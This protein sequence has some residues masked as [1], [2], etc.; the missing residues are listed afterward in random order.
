MSPKIGQRWIRE[1]GSSKI[2][3]EVLSG[4]PNL[5]GVI[6]QVIQNGNDCFS[7]GSKDSW[8]FIDIG[9]VKYTYLNGQDRSSE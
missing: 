8:G 5:L 7:L 9:S 1:H 6:V 4:R 2:I 3:I